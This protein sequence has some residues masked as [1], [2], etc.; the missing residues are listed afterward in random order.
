[1]DKSI[2]NSFFD[3]NNSYQ[4]ILPDVGPVNVLYV[5]YVLK[6]SQMTKKLRKNK[7][8]NKCDILITNAN[9]IF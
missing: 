3:T 8:K 1:M 6:R 7:F 2:C 5:I 9:E 4:N